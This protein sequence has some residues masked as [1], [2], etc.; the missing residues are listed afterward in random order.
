MVAAGAVEYIDWISAER[1]DFPNVCSE[2]DT[3][4]SDIKASVMLELWQIQSTPSLS[5]LPSLRWPIVGA[6]DRVISLGQI[7]LFH[8]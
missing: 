7:E 5:S 2:Y 3:K 1:K 4:Q 6:P 8:I